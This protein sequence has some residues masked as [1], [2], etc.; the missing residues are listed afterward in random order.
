MIEILR[1]FPANVIAF[2]GSGH[3]TRRDYDDVLVPAVE[4]ALKRHDKIRLFYKIGPDFTGIEAGAVWEDFSVGV[5]H[6]TAWERIAIVTD[7]AWIANTMRAFSFLI[8]AAAKVFPL[9]E[10]AAARS[11]IAA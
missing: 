7:V 10:E 4:N 8:P 1:D 5:A 3:V 6:F 9:S 11:W 2:Q